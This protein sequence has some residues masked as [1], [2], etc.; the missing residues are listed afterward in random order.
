M[1][2]RVSLFGNDT[3]ANDRRLV[4]VGKAEVGFLCLLNWPHGG[5][6]GFFFCWDCEVIP[7]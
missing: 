7:W 3:R 4:F 1:G 6:R 2:Y 5:G